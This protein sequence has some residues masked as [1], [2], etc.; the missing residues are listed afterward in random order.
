[1]NEPEQSWQALTGDHGAGD[2]TLSD[3]IAA[4]VAGELEGIA[5]DLFGGGDEA[6]AARL[7]KIAAGIRGLEGKP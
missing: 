4:N 3:L 5:V 1:M 6:N 2:A 7:R